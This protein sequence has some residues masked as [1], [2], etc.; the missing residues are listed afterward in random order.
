MSTVRVSRCHSMVGRKFSRWFCLEDSGR[1]SHRKV[2]VRCECG[3]EKRV[4]LNNLIR[5]KSQSCGCLRGEISSLRSTTHGQT[6]NGVK[7]PTYRTWIAMNRRCHDQKATNYGW[8][9]GRGIYVCPR[10]RDSFDAFLADVGERPSGLTLDRID[11]N[12]HYEPG[13]VRWATHKQQSLNRR[14]RRDEYELERRKLRDCRR[15][16]A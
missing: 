14:P 1:G 12:G 8:Y 9:G 3:T 13:N 6:A 11:N 16:S 4:N 15:V 7:S 2:L 5:G 10:W